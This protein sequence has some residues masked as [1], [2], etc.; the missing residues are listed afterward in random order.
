MA[1]GTI[2]DR[3]NSC[4][5]CQASVV[6]LAERWSATPEVVGSLPIAR[7]K[8]WTERKADMEHEMILFSAD[9][10]TVCARLTARRKN[11]APEV[12]QDAYPIRTRMDPVRV[13]AGAPQDDEPEAA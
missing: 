10:K 1:F 13:G 5:R 9:L 2:S 3:F 8:F 11:K 6:Q 12:Q 4:S 7:S